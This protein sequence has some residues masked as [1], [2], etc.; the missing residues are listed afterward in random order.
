MSF[1]N[2][3]FPQ[4]GNSIYSVEAPP[5]CWCQ[6]LSP[7]SGHMHGYQEKGESPGPQ[8]EWSLQNIREIMRM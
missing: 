3:R 1:I 5:G 7:L 2:Q 6:E 4:T 8:Q